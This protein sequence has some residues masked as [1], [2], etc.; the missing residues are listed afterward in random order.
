MSFI[1]SYKYLYDSLGD[2]TML[3][4]VRFQCCD[5]A[6]HLNNTE[7]PVGWENYPPPV[8]TAE[9]AE[10]LRVVVATEL[11]KNSSEIGGF[12]S[13]QEILANIAKSS[14]KTD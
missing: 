2:D 12:P 9:Q 5:G 6:G 4:N 1:I 7:V 14:R 11:A 3:N 13:V 10:I 8:V